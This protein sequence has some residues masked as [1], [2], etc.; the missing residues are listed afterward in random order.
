MNQ[1]NRSLNV[2]E[3]LGYDT[4]MQEKGVTASAE[5]DCVMVQ[6]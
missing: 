4:L 6:Q 5:E 2:I 3:G 1:I